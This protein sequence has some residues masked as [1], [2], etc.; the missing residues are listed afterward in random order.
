MDVK[1][2]QLHIV[3][4]P[5]PVLRRTAVAIESV[6]DSVRDIAERMIEL[7]HE[8]Q[9]VG[10][11]APQ[12]GLSLRMFVVNDPEAPD[13]SERVF[14]NPVLS[15]P[16]T[17]NATR[18]EG[19]LSLPGINVDVKRP[20]GITIEATDLHGE[21]FTLTSRDIAARIWQHEYDHLDGVLILDKM[22]ALDKLA[23][24]RAIKELEA[25]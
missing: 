20:V 21:R 7:M 5:D 2:D 15:D 14:I 24:R 10:L 13:K 6:D 3:D 11:A 1:V 8:A 23:N 17:E 25:K 19:C 4:Y 12:V 18:Q 22:S 16:E 9:G